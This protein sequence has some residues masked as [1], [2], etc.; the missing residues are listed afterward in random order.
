MGSLG[1]V[2]NLAVVTVYE[3]DVGEVLLVL[4]IGVPVVALLG[5]ACHSSGN[6]GLGNLLLSAAAFGVL[7]FLM[8][9]C[10]TVTGI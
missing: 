2:L 7:P 9:S 6:S 10:Q 1:E 4:G 5:M 3:E 8:L